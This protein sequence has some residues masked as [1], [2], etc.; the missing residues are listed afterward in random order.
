M[1]EALNLYF[2]TVFEGDD[3][4]N[5]DHANVSSSVPSIGSEIAISRT[6]IKNIVMKMKSNKACGPDGISMRILK[7]G[8]DSLSVALEIIFKRSM[9]FTE[10]PNDWKLANVAPIFKKGSKKVTSNYRPVSLTSVVCKILE[11]IIKINVTQHLDRHGLI[12]NNQHGF[13]EGKSCLTNL[14][15]YL[16]F[17]TDMVDKGNDMDVIYLDFSKAFDKVS[18]KMLVEKL[19]LYGIIG[20]VNEWIEDWLKDRMQR[21]QINGE[22]SNW[23]SV[24]SGVPQ[25]SVLGP[26]LFLIYVDDM[27]DRIR[28]NSRVWKFADDTKIAAP[29]NDYVGGIGLQKNLDKLMVWAS[30]WNMTFNIDKCKVM[31][32]GANNI[33]FSYEMRG[34][35]LNKVTQ[36]KDLGIIVENN[37]KPS[38]QCIEARNRANKILGAINRNV[39]YK[40]K[41]VVSKLYTS[42]VRPHLEYCI[43]AWS[44]YYIQDL[45]MLERV[46]RR[47]TKLIPAIKRLEYKDRLKELNM[48]SIKRRCIRG[49]M[50]QVY[51]MG[52][53]G[54]ETSF[55]AMFRLDASNRV[56]G[57]D[58]KLKKEHCRLD[59]RKNFFSQRVINFWNGLPPE[60]VNSPSLEIFKSRIDLFMNELDL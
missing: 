12:N 45:G 50:I 37:L 51:K 13:R 43:Q 57:H 38:K 11:K 54:N 46:Q 3:S 24:R 22:R 56:R 44:P 20:Q 8:V 35:W 36:E 1:A 15:D 21:V 7:E 60:V 6:D 40:S 27:E 52:A 32:L 26:L 53:S 34:N 30:E 17:V 28:N 4:R 14:L 41:E 5:R 47:A 29:V 48:F 25:G 23:I 55:Q 39:V 18:H 42:L 33:N 9:N 19:K 31:H 49:D 10:I 59:S 2:G 58:R 16:E